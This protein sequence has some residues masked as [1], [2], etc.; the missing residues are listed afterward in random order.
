MLIFIDACTSCNI[1][2][3][4][5]F[6]KPN[7]Q[8]RAVKPTLKLSISFVHFLREGWKI[9]N[10][11]WGGAES[12]VYWWRHYYL[13]RHPPSQII[14]QISSQNFNLGLHFLVMSSIVLCY[15]EV[16]RFIILPSSTYSALCP[17]TSMWFRSQVVVF[18]LIV[19]VKLSYSKHCFTKSGCVFLHKWRVTQMWK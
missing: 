15:L 1:N 8:V 9:P 5:N 14:A 13:V 7:A 2:S 10:N 18:Y 6:K 16:D 4:F 12:R 3:I 17:G 19:T 11:E